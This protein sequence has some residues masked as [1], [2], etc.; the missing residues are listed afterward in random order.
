MATIEYNWIK[1][2]NPIRI[3]E[4]ANSLG[5]NLRTIDYDGIADELWRMIDEKIRNRIISDLDKLWEEHTEGNQALSDVIQGVYV[6]TLSDNLSINYKECPSKVIYVGRGKIRSR[7]TSHLKYWIRYL[8]DSLQD[9]ALDIW[10][11]EIRVNGN[12]NA[13]KEVETDL[14]NFF[15]EKYRCYPLQNKKAGDY[16]EKNH[17]YCSDWNLPL[18]NRSNIQYGWS[19]M[20]LKNN[21][22]AFTFEDE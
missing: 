17:E 13:F 7:I 12:R 2:K 22:W 8:S 16:H 20:P 5:F 1:T 19:I 9:I 15:Y 10:M 6:I 3:S 14:L 18:R 11:A 4:Y 21:P